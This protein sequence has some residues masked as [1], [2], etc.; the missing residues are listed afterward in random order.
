MSGLLIYIV[1][2]N[3]KLYSDVANLFWTR[4]ISNVIALDKINNILANTKTSF[5]ADES[6][7]NITRYIKILI[8]IVVIGNTLNC[9][10]YF[11]DKFDIAIDFF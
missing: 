10:R 3:F 4:I 1:F 11:D 9:I 5:M 8:I 2:N 6:I 7:T